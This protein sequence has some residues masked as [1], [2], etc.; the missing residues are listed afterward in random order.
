[1]DCYTERA[2]LLALLAWNKPSRL[3]IDIKGEEGFQTVVAIK[4]DGRWLCWH[5][6]DD[7]LPLFERIPKYAQS[8]Y[9]GHTTEEKYAHIAKCLGVSANIAPTSRTDAAMRN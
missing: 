1:M 6:A 8:V 3:Y 5:I 9:D 2:H 4:L 7:D